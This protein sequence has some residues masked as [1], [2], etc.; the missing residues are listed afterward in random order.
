M[1]YEITDLRFPWQTA[2][3]SVMGVGMLALFVTNQNSMSQ[4]VLA[5]VS[6][7]KIPS[8]YA[9]RK[10]IALPLAIG[11]GFV[12]TVAGSCDLLALQSDLTFPGFI[13]GSIITLLAIPADVIAQLS[14]L[15]GPSAATLFRRIP[16]R[17]I[18]FLATYCALFYMLSGVALYADSINQSLWKIGWTSKPLLELSPSTAT[19]WIL[20]GLHIVFCLIYGVRTY[21]DYRPRFVEILSGGD[22]DRA[23]LINDDAPTVMS[24]YTMPN[25]FNLLGVFAALYKTFSTFVSLLSISRLFLDIEK[26]DASILFYKAFLGLTQ[27]CNFLVQLT[28]YSKTNVQLHHEEA[29]PETAGMCWWSSLFCRRTNNE[30]PGVTADTAVSPDSPC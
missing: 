11:S 12:K 14:N 9:L 24:N 27:I 25:Y 16:H 18:P 3:L 4:R 17:A 28:F 1:Q 10:K 22:P 29:D 13:V 23:P 7:K 2:V 30:D 8:T 15:V 21:Q 6:D 26:R 19:F 5:L 20:N